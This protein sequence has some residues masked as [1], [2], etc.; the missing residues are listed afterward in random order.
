[1]AEARGIAGGQRGPWGVCVARSRHREPGHQLAVRR[2]AAA[3]PVRRRRHHRRDRRGA[4]AQRVLRPHRAA[5]EEGQAARARHRVDRRPGA[6]RTSSSTR[7]ARRVARLARART[8]R[9]SRARRAACSTTG[10]GPDR[11]RRLFF[12]Q[13]EAVETAIYLTEVRRASSGDAWIDER[14]REARTRRPTPASTASPSRWRP[15]RGKTVVMAM[16]I[17]WQALNKL[18]NPQDARFSDALPRRH[19][20]H[21]H[22]RPPARAAAQR[23]GQLLPPARPRAAGAAGAARARRR[24]SITNFHAFLPREQVDGRQADQEDP[25][26]HGERQP[27]SPRRRTRWSAASAASWATRSNIVVINDEAH[28]CYRRKPVEADEE[29]LDR[30][31]AHARPSSATRRRASGSRGLEAVKRQDRRPGGLRPLGHA[32]LPARLRLPRGHALPLG[33]LRLLADRR[34][35]VR[36]SSRCPRVPVADD[37]MTGEQPDL[38]R[39]LAAHPRATCRRRAARPTRSAA[40]RSCPSELEGALHSLYGNYEK[41]YRRWEQNAEAR[42]RGH[43]AAGLHRRLQQHQRLQARLRLDRRLGEGRCPTAR[44]S[45]VPGQAAAL[46]QRARTAAGPRR[47]NTILVDSRAARVG[48]GDERRVQE[49]R[50]RA[51]SRSS[52]PSTAQRFPGR[53]ADDAHRRG[54]AARGDEHGRQAGQARRAGPVRRRRSRCSPRAGTPTPSPTSSASAP[55]ARSSSASRSSAA[56][57]RRTSYAANDEGMF[58]PEYAEVYG[59]PFSFIPAAGSRRSASRA[60]ETPTRVR[61]LEERVACEITFPRARSATATSCRASG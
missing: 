26:R 46:Q 49:D 31:R 22:P 58:E 60:A 61:A 52:R 36:A 57:L 13:I 10:S 18:A 4:P 21:H 2:A 38:P 44:R 40:S 37:A 15:A 54:P 41:Y 19:A 55:S 34:D 25:R 16:L 23:P 53:D 9:A 45:L 47:P 28:H 29:K 14:A 33:R 35:R 24:S 17:A 43:D 3:L 32:V 7:S 11:E 6:A 12:C 59:V 50:G 30:R 39:P 51:R 48:R 1:M 8:T 5:Q 20:G 56:A 42:A 27:A